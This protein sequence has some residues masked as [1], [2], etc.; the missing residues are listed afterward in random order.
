MGVEKTHV[1]DSSSQSN[2]PRAH[3]V[4]KIQDPAIAGYSSTISLMIMERVIPFGLT[5]NLGDACIILSTISFT[6]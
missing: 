3:S 6:W 1:I 2:L 4:T 5:R